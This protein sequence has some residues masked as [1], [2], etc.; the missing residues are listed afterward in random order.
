VF[1]FG[2]FEVNTDYGRQILESID[3]TTG[4]GGEPDSSGGLYLWA[5]YKSDND[6]AFA[7]ND[8][9]AYTMYNGTAYNIGQTLNYI[10]ANCCGGGCSSDGCD[11]DSYEGCDDE[12]CPGY[13]GGGCIPEGAECIPEGCGTCDGCDGEVTPCSSCDYA[14]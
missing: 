7:V 6:Y 12:D 8:A 2:D 14:E 9:G 3:E 4:M 10:L 13:G 1:Q 11:C 5:G